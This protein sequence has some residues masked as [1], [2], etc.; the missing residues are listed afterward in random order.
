MRGGG[1]VVI[2]CW[3]VVGA[4]VDTARAGVGRGRGRWRCRRGREERGGGRGTG[5]REWLRRLEAMW[6]DGGGGVIRW[7]QREEQ[8]LPNM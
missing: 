4:F 7:D 2:P 8:W 6:S 1:L 3:R 5:R